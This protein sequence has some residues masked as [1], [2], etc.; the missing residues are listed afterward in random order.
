[1]RL[2]N[3][4]PYQTS[5]IAKVNTNRNPT[6][7][8]RLLCSDEAEYCLGSDSAK[9]L[10]SNSAIV[11]SSDV[12]NSGT[13]LS[14]FWFPANDTWS[15]QHGA[16]LCSRPRRVHP[17]SNII[18]KVAH[19]LQP[20][21]GGPQMDFGTINRHHSRDSEGRGCASLANENLPRAIEPTVRGYS[22]PDSA[23]ASGCSF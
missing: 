6:P 10:S 2:N 8:T 22:L 9:S 4:Q 3:P 14:S 15:K 12:V 18:L 19:N 21:P 5:Q 23:F 16:H 7:N 11:S 17:L 1:M 13:S 20:Y